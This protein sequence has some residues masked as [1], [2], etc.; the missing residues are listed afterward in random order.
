M[1]VSATLLDELTSSLLRPKFRR[2][3]VEDEVVRF[4]ETLRLA[5]V[6]VDDTARVQRR[7][8]DPGD[9]YLI[10]LARAADATVLVSGDRD[11]TSIG[12]DDPGIVT[13][14]RFLSTIEVSEGQS[15]PE[16]PSDR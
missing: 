16:E 5:A 11:L 1:V 7:S 10:A 6:V 14:R 4:V 12:G 13:P 15:P 9:D 3:I 2:W 8:R